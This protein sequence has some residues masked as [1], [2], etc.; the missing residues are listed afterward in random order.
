MVNPLDDETTVWKVC[1]VG[2]EIKADWFVTQMCLTESN[3]LANTIRCHKSQRTF[4]WALHLRCAYPISKTSLEHWTILFRPFLSNESMTSTQLEQ[5]AKKR[6][7]R[8]LGK[9]LDLWNIR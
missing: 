2:R 9:I 7:A 5:V 1:K 4:I 8:D 3:V 6:N